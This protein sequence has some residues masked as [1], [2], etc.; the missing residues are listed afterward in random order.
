MGG[1]LLSNLLILV[2]G[3]PGT[4]SSLGH[5]RSDIHALC[6][7]HLG[8]VQLWIE[9]RF[10]SQGSELLALFRYCSNFSALAY[11]VPEVG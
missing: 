6:S 7:N 5:P 10:V 8:E 4:P 1:I 3:N 9:A 2:I 11:R